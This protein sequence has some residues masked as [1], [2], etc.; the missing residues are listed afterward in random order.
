MVGDI[1]D[2]AQVRLDIRLPVRFR[3][4]GLA[5]GGQFATGKGVNTR[6]AM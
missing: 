4:L 5:C 3:P 6:S 1:A 2:D